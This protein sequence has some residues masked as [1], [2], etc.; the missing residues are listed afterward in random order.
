MSKVI[1][2]SN[3]EYRTQSIFYFTLVTDMGSNRQLPV[4][5]KRQMITLTTCYEI[6]TLTTYYLVLCDLDTFSC[7]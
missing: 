3:I 6:T 2:Y 1:K 7:I 5:N 4:N